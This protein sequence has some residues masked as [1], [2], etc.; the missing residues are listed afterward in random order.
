MKWLIFFILTVAA[1]YLYIRYGKSLSLGD[2]NPPQATEKPVLQEKL[3]ER[4]TGDELGGTAV[5]PTGPR[6]AQ[7]P[8]NVP[9]VNPPA[10]QPN[11]DR[12]QPPQ[13]EGNFEP[14]P[15]PPMEQPYNDPN[16][17]QVMPPDMEVPPPPQFY[18]DNEMGNSVPI[19]ENP[20][21]FEAPPD[22]N[23]EFYTPPPPPPPMDN[24][25][26]F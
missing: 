18:Q 3:N 4:E 10:P 14:P 20:S 9:L 17:P 11:Y 23:N 7:Q 5:Q 1:C 21:P 25:E 8:T 16:I 15:P 22:S 13:S 6:G 19:P 12:Y 2:K 24:N 26:N